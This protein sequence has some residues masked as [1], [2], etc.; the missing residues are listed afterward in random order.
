MSNE[1]PFWETKP[2]SQMTREEWESLCD[3][4]GRCCLITLEDEDA[5]GIFEETSVHCR[6]FDPEERRCTCYAR[7]TTLVPG[8]VELKP[9]NVGNLDFMPA[10]CAYRRLAEGRGLAP[11]HPLIS[12]DPASVEAA[13]IAV[14][15][16]LVSEREVCEEDLWHHL[17][18]EQRRG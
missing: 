7:R 17:T 10:S 18:G 16:D 5:P 13:G 9:G 15:K 3:G 8:C 6:L 2:L 4:C 12:G 11:W 1:L 14:P